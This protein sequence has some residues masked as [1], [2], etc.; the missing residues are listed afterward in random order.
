MISVSS[1][2]PSSNVSL[3]FLFHVF[4]FVIMRKMLCLVKSGSSFVFVDLFG[5]KVVC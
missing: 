5:L 3:F 1:L 2:K 4:P